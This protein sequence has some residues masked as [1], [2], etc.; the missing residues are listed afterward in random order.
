M[1]N[2]DD[3]RGFSG[4]SGLLPDIDAAGETSG[5]V[6]PSSLSQPESDPKVGGV[7]GNEKTLSSPSV[8]RSKKGKKARG[9][10]GKWILALIFI[11]LVVTL[12][13]IGLHTPTVSTSYV[14]PIADFSLNDLN[15]DI[16]TPPVLTTASYYVI[17]KKL[18]MREKPG[19][20]APVLN[21][22]SQFKT[23]ELFLN[24]RTNGWVKVDDGSS[25]GWVA[26]KFLGKG[27]GAS[28]RMAYWRE[29]VVYPPS[30]YI[31]EQSKKG[32]HML[33]IK[34]GPKFDVIAKLKDI[35]GNTII[36]IFVH[37]NDRIS[38]K[39]IPSGRYKFQYATG[40]SFCRVCGDKFLDEMQASEDTKYISYE[41]TSDAY[42]R[43]TASMEY[44]LFRVANGNLHTNQV[45]VGQF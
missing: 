17:P 16:K 3:N 13:R 10:G 44:T 23:V 27:N 31:L 40:R 30:G 39:S 28:A 19:S 22:L 18:N 26:E 15:M 35:N 32:P 24:S 9:S 1:G 45:P 43:Y 11:S 2:K 36:S 4:L 5:Q 42:N 21:A 7:E 34:N 12:V 29:N 20:K 6:S 25:V 37:A 41:V 8:K 14:A 38:I 33:T